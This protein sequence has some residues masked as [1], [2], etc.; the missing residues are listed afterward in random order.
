MLK[1][2]KVFTPE[3]VNTMRHAIERVRA[4]R[5][6]PLRGAEAERLALKALALFKIGYTVEAALVRAL[7]DEG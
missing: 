1:Q 2:T 3:N 7:R 6:L 4:R 5:R